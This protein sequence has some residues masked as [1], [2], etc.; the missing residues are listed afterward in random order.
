MARA[1]TAL[2]GGQRLSFEQAML[3]CRIYGHA[4]DEFFPNNMGVPIGGWRL[5]LRCMRCTTERHDIIDHRGAVSNRRYIYVDGYSQAGDEKPTREEMRQN[6]LA[7][8]REKLRA[9]KAINAN[10]VKKSA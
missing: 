10:I 4:W 2:I 1:H 5:S 7:T 9:A 8:V 6:M 3:R